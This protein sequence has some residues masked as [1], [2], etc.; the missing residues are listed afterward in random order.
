MDHAN[1]SLGSL[2]IITLSS[3]S[4]ETEMFIIVDLHHTNY[5]NAR[6]LGRQAV[7]ADDARTRETDFKVKC[8]P[9]FVINFFTL[10]PFHFTAKLGNKIKFKMDENDVSLE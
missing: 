9:H 2:E 10:I 1:S 7:T 3:P 8:Q 6:F 5:D 4:D